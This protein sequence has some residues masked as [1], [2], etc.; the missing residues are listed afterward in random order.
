MHAHVSAARR[1]QALEEELGYWLH[2]A[3]ADPDYAASF[4]EVAPQSGQ[5]ASAYLDRWLPL[6]SGGH[7]LAGPR[8]FGRDPDLPFVG[9]SASDRPLTV[10][11]RHAFCAV[12]LEHFA[13]FRPGFV[14]LTTADPVGAWPG[15]RAVM[16]QLVGLL[17]E[18]R[19]RRTPPELSV[20]RRDDAAA[21]YD[22]YVAIHR[23]H[24]EQEP[25]HARRTRVEELTD[26]QRIADEELLFDVCV[27]GDWA[28]LLAAEDEMR[29]GIS[30]ATVVELMLDHAYRGR[31]YGAHLSTLLARAVPLTDDAFLMGTIYA[32]NV[33]AYR[34]A[35][36]AGRVDVGGE[37][38]ISL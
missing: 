30:G 10:D 31:G 26:L 29:R 5:P 8:Y 14:L 23:I 34:S 37:I 25:A 19:R 32:D 24:V 18:L 22:R 12:A 4:A 1:R 13:P 38:A 6:S 7:V 11:D 17:G 27:D 35:L 9:I 16:R 36:R 21:I 33:R 3:A 2:T 15:T 20:A 28:G